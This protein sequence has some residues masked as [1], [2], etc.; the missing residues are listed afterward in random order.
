MGLLVSSMRLTLQANLRL[1][2]FIPDKLVIGEASIGGHDN[3][4]WVDI[5]RNTQLFKTGA[6][7]P[8]STVSSKGLRLYYKF[9]STALEFVCQQRGCSCPNV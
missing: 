3:A 4:F 8:T 2:K 9:W 6:D 7:P 5:L 1:F